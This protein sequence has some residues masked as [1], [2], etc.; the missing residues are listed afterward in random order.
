MYAKYYPSALAAA[1]KLADNH[2]CLL[3]RVLAWQEVIY[4][5]QSLPVWLR[6]SLVNVLYMITEDGM[7]AQKQAPLP[8]WVNEQDGLFGLNE[9]PRGCPQIE[10]IPCSFYGNAPIIYFFPELALSTYRGYKNYQFPDGAPPWIFGGCTGGTPPV[11][12]ANTTRGYQFAT[13]GISLAA[14]LDRYYLCYSDQDPGFVN[15]FYPM[16]KQCM[17]WTVN[18]RPAYPIGE[19][20]IAMPTGDAG[21]EWFEA[22]DPGWYG[23]A[24]HIGGLHLAQLRI[25][26]RFAGLAGDTAFAQECQAWISSAA[27]VMQTQLWTGTYYLNYFEPETGRKSDL[28]F[29]YQLDGQWITDHHGLLTALPK[30]QVQTTLETIKGNV[31]LSST[32]AVNYANPDGT[33]TDVGGYGPYSY[34]PPE[35]LMLA[36]TYIY[37][38]QIDYGLDLAYKVWHNLVCAQGYTWD[39]PNIMNG[40]VDNGRRSYGW[41]YYQDMMLWSL[42][43]A[44]AGL[45]FGRPAKPGGL[46]ARVLE[47]S[48][49]LITVTRSGSNLVLSWAGPGTLQSAPNANGPYVDVQNSSSPYTVTTKGSQ[50]F[51]R[52]RYQLTNRSVTVIE[53]SRMGFRRHGLFSY[54]FQ[55]MGSS[56]KFVPEVL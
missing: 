53:T 23:M 36:M 2:A 48:A 15:E 8:D 46:V 42:P 1:Q 14:M 52:V 41:D 25:T 50:M 43:A 12:F 3:Q 16:L 4:C 47:A 56:G 51:F 44:L 32:G 27:E 17:I 9:S 29:G 55:G 19:S 39:M 24:A 38:G 10:C 18:L 22:S 11:D 31:A 20:I 13:N 30:A 6:D 34:F 26:Q 33:L 5:E 49:P 45:D 40:S 35:A 28:V 37:E 7:W 54:L 21:A